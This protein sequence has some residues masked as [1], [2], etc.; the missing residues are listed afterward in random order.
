MSS[1]QLRYTFNSATL[2]LVALSGFSGCGDSPSEPGLPDFLLTSIVFTGD[3]IGD[4]PVASALTGAARTGSKGEPYCEVT[5]SWSPPYHQRVVSYSVHRA[6]SPGISEGGVDFRTLGTT[7]MLSFPDSDSLSWGTEYYYAISALLADST[8]LWSN[9]EAFATPTTDYPVLSVLAAEDLLLGH[10]LL[11]W[12]PCPDQDFAGYT[13]TV[14]F[15]LYSPPDTMGVFHDVNDTL[16][17]GSA[18][19]NYPVYFQVATTDAEGHASTS[20]LLQYTHNGPLPWRIGSLGYLYQQYED[21]YITG[22]WITSYNG[23]YLYFRDRVYTPPYYECTY[24]INRIGTVQGVYKRRQ[25]A[26]E[27]SSI[28][29]LS[30]RNGVLVSYDDTDGMYLELLDENTLQTVGTYPVDFTCNSM[31]AGASDAR[32]IL[33]PEGS[34]TSLVL[35]MNSMSFVDTLDFTVSQG[36]VLGRYGTYIWGGAE[37]LCRLDPATLAIDATCPIMVSCNPVATSNGE[38]C[39]LSGTGNNNLYSLDPFSL[40]VLDIREMPELPLRTVIYE[41]SGDVFAYYRNHPFY[42]DSI[43]VMNTGNLD[44]AGKIY[45]TQETTNPMMIA[46]PEQEKIWCLFWTDE[47]NP[48]HLSIIR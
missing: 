7:S 32:V 18:N 21:I 10:C 19:P 48:G 24:G 36:Q 15:G 28:C 26:N 22:E 9:E 1:R 43:V 12:S 47:L 25:M 20:N 35:D 38:L 31:I 14:R 46:L 13:V 5:V 16:C 23:E 11:H 42:P 34:Q 33:C 2:L 29:H 8:V 39:V 41:A 44:I 30:S 3:S 27:P 6:I 4:A 37:G 40:D 17:V 45:L